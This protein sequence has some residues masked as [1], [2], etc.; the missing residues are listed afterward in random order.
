MH[1]RIACTSD[2]IEHVSWDPVPCRY[3]RYLAGITG[4]LQVSPVPCRYHRYLADITGTLQ[5]SPVPCR[6]HQISAGMSRSNVPRPLGA[7]LKDLVSTPRFKTRFSS[8][9]IVAAWTDIAGERIGKE[10]E[11]AWVKDKKLFVRIKSSVWRH[12]LHLNR[13]SWRQRLNEELGDE[14][15]K[16]IIFR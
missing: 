15:V 5:V 3:H 16:E 12:E 1:I 11:R 7:V 6:Y 4:T 14:R 13:T 2:F 10:V 9:Q 8:A